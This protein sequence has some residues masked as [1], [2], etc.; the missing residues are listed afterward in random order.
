MR[1]A[2]GIA[3][4]SV[5]TVGVLGLAACSTGA[6]A[7]ESSSSAPAESEKAPAKGASADLTPENF[8]QRISDAQLAAGSVSMATSTQ[9]QGVSMDMTGDVVFTDGSQNLSMTM[10][11]PGSGEMQIRFVDDVFYMNMGELS[12]NKFVAIDPADPSNPMASSFEGLTEQMDPSA[13]TEALQGAITSI[14]KKGEPV[15]I[16]G[17]KAQEYTVTV[18]TTKLSDGTLQEQAEAAGTP[19]PE[20]LTYQYWVDADDLMRKIVMDVM[21][22]STEMTF[23]KWGE[24]L[25]ITAPTAE[26]ISTEPLF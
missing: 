15:D 19:L 23:S 11:V 12:Q 18:D 5:A 4:L 6:S 3:A 13:S 24:D 1:L 14:E 16:D 10:T 21:G 7:P 20:T 8:V 22:T 25:A 9:V 26:E 2:R 17:V